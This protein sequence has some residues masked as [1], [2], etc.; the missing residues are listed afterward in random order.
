M[1]VNKTRLNKKPT[2]LNRKIQTRFKH[3]H[4]LDVPIKWQW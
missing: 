3:L 4:G 2:R 1:R